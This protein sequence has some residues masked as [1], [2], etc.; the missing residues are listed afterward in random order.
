[1]GHD[2]DNA[3]KVRIPTGSGDV[4]PLKL[5]L[6][7][8]GTLPVFGVRVSPLSTDL[9]QSAS[10]TSPPCC[11]VTSGH[12]LDL[13]CWYWRETGCVVWLVTHH[14]PAYIM[15]RPQGLI[16]RPYLIWSWLL[17]WPFWHNV[18][19][20]YLLRSLP[21]TNIITCSEYLYWTRFSPI[22]W[23]QGDMNPPKDRWP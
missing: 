23:C 22:A 20:P 13:N 3:A 8:E 16:H 2:S 7:L 11:E 17:P 18:H 9:G 21:P 6:T 5:I 14:V 12:G 15:D 4:G 19:Y 10:L 1:M